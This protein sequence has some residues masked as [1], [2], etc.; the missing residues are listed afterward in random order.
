MYSFTYRYIHKSEKAMA[1]HSS[2]LAWKI[3][4]TEKPG[5]L[6]SMGLQSQTR[7]SDIP[8]TFH[9]HVNDRIRSTYMYFTEVLVSQLVF[10][11][12]EQNCSHELH[13]ETLV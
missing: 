5:G 7:L 13:D 9:F 1:P 12:S 11:G 2:T 4:W 3:S 8:F 6:Q 10:S